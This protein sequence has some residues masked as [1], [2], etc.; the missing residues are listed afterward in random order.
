MHVVVLKNDSKVKNKIREELI[1][2]GISHVT[3]EIESEDEECI[4]I[5]CH[6]DN[7]KVSHHHNH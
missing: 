2:H 7:K 5:K 1:E 6:V 3:I 4:D